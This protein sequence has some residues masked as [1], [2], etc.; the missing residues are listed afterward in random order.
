MKRIFTVIILFL[1]FGSVGFSQLI[2]GCA[3]TS[4][5]NKDSRPDLGI[6]IYSSDEE[7]VWNAL[8]LATYSQSKGD[9]VVIF[10]IGKGIDPFMKDTNSFDIKPLQFK[11]LSNGGQIIACGT[12]AKLR[13]TDEIKMCTIASITDLYEIIRRSKK[14]ISF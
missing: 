13:G 6:V 11:F 12:C 8:R 3:G 1:C 7:T 4:A 14:T 10:L 5:F 2:A 9:S